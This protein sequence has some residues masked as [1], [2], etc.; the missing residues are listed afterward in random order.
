[1]VDVMRLH[2][3]GSIVNT[4]SIAGLV[5]DP[6]LPV[7]GATKSALLG[8]TRSIAVDYAADGIRCNC[9]SPGDMET[10]MLETALSQSGD[11]K[12]LRRELQSH[13]PA[14]RFAEP[15]EVA[16]AVVFLLSNE[17]SFIT[18]ATLVVDGGLT[19]NCY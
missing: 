15:E 19:A 10:P 1:A 12:A 11:P 8:L 7:Y 16:P 6:T 17:A 3:G 9:V 2:G 14:R 5:G 4:G 13:Y 18:G